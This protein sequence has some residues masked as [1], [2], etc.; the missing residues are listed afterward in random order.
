MS[1]GS[2]KQNCNF[3]PL[4]NTLFIRKD[5]INKRENKKGR[6]GKNDSGKRE[7]VLKRE[8]INAMKLIK[9]I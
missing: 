7:R 8:Y 4:K 9:I 5:G 6:R 1:L 2:S 3:F